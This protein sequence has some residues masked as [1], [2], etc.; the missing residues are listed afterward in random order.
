MPRSVKGMKHFT[1]SQLRRQNLTVLIIIA[2]VII[3]GLITHQVFNQ[4]LRAINASDPTVV[5]VTIPR[6]A[7]D[8]EVALL[9]K[10][11]HLVRSAFVF[12]YYLQT[13]KTTG[14]KAGQFKM[15]R[16]MSTPQ[17]VRNLQKRQM[18]KV[19]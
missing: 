17:I 19:K 4:S 18:A 5:K 10:Q 13:H 6:G 2:L 8:K 14:V 12:D 1:K 16:K 9:L 15:T 11:H 7:T 3:G